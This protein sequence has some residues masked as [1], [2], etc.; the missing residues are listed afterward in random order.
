LSVLK[1][2]HLILILILSTS[3]FVSQQYGNEWIKYNQQ[4]FHFPIVQTGVHR[5]YYNTIN[6]VLNQQGIDISQINHTQFQIFGREKEVSILVNDI[7]NNNLLDQNEYVE[8]YAEKNDG[9]LDDLVYDSSN[10]IPDKFFSL[11]NDTI[12][13]Y[14]TWNNAFN[15]KRTLIESDI[16][17]N[18]YGSASFCWKRTLNKYTSS[19]VLGEQSSGI[20]SPKYSVGEGWAGSQHSKNGSYSENLSSN[21]F[22]SGGPNAY[23]KI[24]VSSTNSSS[25]N[26]ENY[27]HNTKFYVNNNIIFDSSYYGYKVFNIDFNFEN[28]NLTNNTIIEHYISNIGQG[29][30]YQHISSIELFYPHNTNFSSYSDIHFGLDFNLNQKQRLTISNIISSSTDPVLYMLDDIHRV[31]PIVQNGGQWE[32]VIPPPSTDTTRLYLFDQNNISEVSSI[33]AINQTGFFNDFSSLQLDSAFVIITHENLLSSARSYAAYRSNK[34]DTIVVNI[35]ELYHQY[36]AGIFKN[37]LSIRRFVKSLMD[38][39]PSWPSHVFLIGKSVRFNDE[40]TPGSRFNNNSYALNLVPSWGYP[41]SDNHML[42]GLVPNKRG[43]PIPIGRLSVST[44]YAVLNYLNKVIELESHQGTNSSYT[45]ANKGWQKNIVHFAGGSDSTEQAYM[46]NNLS[47]F[48]KIIED[49]LYG[50]YVRTFGKDPFSSIINPFE[51]QEVQN[52]V[53]NGVSLITFFGHASSGGGFSQ[54]IDDPENWNNQGKYPMVIG[55][56]CYSGD[57]HNPDTA[58]FSEQLIRPN[59]SGAIGFISTIKQGFI[60]FINNYTENLYEMIS[61]FGYHK[62]IG[63]QMVMTLDSLDVLTSSSYWG[64]KFEGNYNGMSLQGDPAILLNSHP[65]AELLIEENNIWT[66]PSTVNL[67]NPDFDLNII[68]NNLGKAVSDSIYMEVKQIFPDGTDTIY[69]KLIGGVKNRDTIIFKIINIPEK[70]IGQN[71]FN[72]SVDLPLSFIVEAEDEIN[73]N[74]VIYSINISS[75]SIIP[76]WPYDFSIIGNPIDTLR[77]ST[78]NPLEKLNTYYFEIDTTDNFNSPFLKKQTLF[79]SGGVIEAAPGNWINNSS[80]LIDSLYFSDSTVYYWRSCP[81]SSV[82][83]WKYRSFQYV[84]NKWGW[85]QAHFDQFSNNSY[86][87]ILFNE[88]NRSFDFA[89]TFKS[90]SCKTYLQHV[91]LTSEW[92]GTL[93]QVNGQ[94]AD[95]GGYITPQ[96][97]I[98]VIDPNTLEYWKTPF[99]D[100]SVSPGVILNPNHCFGQWNG[101]PG[102]CGNTTLWGRNREHGHFIFNYNNTTHLDSLAAML[103]NKIPEGHY[104]IAYSY[105]PNNYGSSLLY[106]DSLYANWP[107]S[108]F[109]SFQN[110]G[111]TGFDNSTQHDD[112]FIFF[113]KKGDLS[114]AITKRSAEITPGLNAQSQLLELNTTVYSN[115]ENG[116]IRSPIIGPSNNWKSIYWSQS[117]LEN[118]SS[119][120]TRIR[121]LGVASPTINQTELLIDTLFT[122]NDSLLNLHP[123]LYK[124]KYLKLEMEAYDDSVLTPAQIGKWQLIYDPLPDLALNPRKSWLFEFD[125]TIV[126]QGDT[127]FL[128]VAI[129]NVTPFH[130]DSLVIEYKIEN[131]NSS[132]LISYPKQDSLRARSL[133]ID[134]I[135]ILTKYLQ[136][137]YNLLITANPLQNTG[138]QHQPEQFYFN[139][140]LQKSFSIQRD[141]INPIL[142]VTFDGVHILNNDIVS[143]KPT[144]I[145][146]LDD[147]NPF[148]ILDQN[149]DTSNFQI[150]IKRPNSNQW[151]KI[152]F[153]G[154]Q[155]VPNLEWNLADEENKFVITYKAN[156]DEDGLYGLRV[157]GQD[158]SGNLSGSTPYEIYFEVI[159]KSSITNLYNYPNPFSTKTNFVFTLTGQNIPDELT[160]QILNISGRLI[161]Q[162][163][164][165]ESENI[166]IGNNITDFYWDGKDEFGD[167]LANG[168][169]L[170][171]VIAKIN[172]E[173]IEHRNSSGDHAFK[174]GFGKMYLI[175]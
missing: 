89:P 117:A 115:L 63:Q 73:N 57:V 109:N 75:N 144:I 102:V 169:Y 105:I 134:T 66:T 44:N 141:I 6:N 160:I 158:Q 21:N 136:N 34:Y 142:D 42:V 116:K 151:E 146:S 122:S 138:A 130:M 86:I 59:Q 119:D 145:I 148:L 112:G 97:M 131:N 111:A 80:N 70:S 28:S 62:T 48:K 7:N 113:C 60:P 96:I 137:Q 93:F 9:W 68:V 65:H 56:G 165:S 15:N 39:S 79:S 47:L 77:V 27:N 164:L 121:I 61:K 72:I 124:Y 126:Q 8:F 19:Y 16:N 92:S 129:E 152:Y 103:D 14:F 30:D 174:K 37:P 24:N 17:Y 69:S 156:F 84:P 90:I 22:Y 132:T 101:D 95:Y 64:P 99:I 10:H 32:A 51:F 128:S 20:S 172:N 167:P 41:S 23:G 123:I 29:T 43:Y 26:Q 5:I 171:R 120:S 3:T 110:L 76:V 149:I 46:R 71:V 35:E 49:T 1:K 78:I 4:Y 159:Q 108:L 18:N 107:T 2:T 153:L 31:I 125:S 74:Q 154:A 94:T 166:K 150:E 114:S 155:G 140:F 25:V 83:D 118:P 100:N 13:Y 175:R 173:E 133:L 85:G 67:S 33:K 58:S 162:L 168:V 40:T 52:I 104:I 11:F 38:L 82:L 50:G 87:N 139:N 163:K 54:N 135:A 55:L 81:D 147:E 127:G 45:V 98:G 157:Q 12:S 143:P 106:S 161:K 53:E 36:S 88:P 91:V 170:Y